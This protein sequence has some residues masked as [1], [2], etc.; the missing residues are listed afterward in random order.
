MLDRC[1]REGNKHFHNY[2]GRGIRVCERWVRFENFLVDMGIAP[3]GM[4][5]E[6]RRNDEGYSKDNC[7]WVPM[8]ANQLNKRTYR[9]VEYRGHVY[10]ILKLSRIVGLPWR[11][12]YQR[13]FDD[14]MDI[15]E[16]VKP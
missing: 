1:S 4:T 12:L 9:R 14:G 13:V 16:A 2:G 8:S 10:T 7:D 3:R 5:L 11:T 6:R 15:N